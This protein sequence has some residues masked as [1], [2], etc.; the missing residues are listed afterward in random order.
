[1]GDVIH[2]YGYINWNGRYIAL[3]YSENNYGIGVD[4]IDPD[5]RIDFSFKTGTS[6]FSIVIEYTK[7]TD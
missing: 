7:S 5:I 4:Y 6:P 2:L 3:P 1:V